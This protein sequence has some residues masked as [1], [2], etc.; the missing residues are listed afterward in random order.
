[1][2]EHFARRPMTDGARRLLEEYDWP[3]NVRELRNLA[4]SAAF[5]MFGEGPI[6]TDALPDWIRSESPAPVPVRAKVSVPSLL[7]SERE[8]VLRALEASAG[9]RSRAARAL[10]ISRQTLYTK[11]AKW[12]LHKSR[13][14]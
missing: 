8:A 10:G 11:M 2:F 6:T 13:A 1:L 14:A 12:G 3:G 9:N 7:L 4:E 5:L